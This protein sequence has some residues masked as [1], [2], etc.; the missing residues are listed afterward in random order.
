MVELVLLVELTSDIIKGN[1]VVEE[2]SGS[3]ILVTVGE[4]ATTVSA[5]SPQNMG[6]ILLT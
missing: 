1:F 5:T 3:R 2:A 6:E 4:A